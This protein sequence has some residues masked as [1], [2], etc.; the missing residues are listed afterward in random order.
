M[1]IPIRFDIKNAGYGMKRYATV[2]EVDAAFWE[3]CMAPSAEEQG[4][5]P[6]DEY[7]IVGMDEHG[8]ESELNQEQVL[9]GMREQGIWGFITEDKRIHFWADEK[10]SVEVLVRFFAHEVGHHTG[11]P[12]EDPLKEEL[13]AEQFASVA[14][15]A[16]Q[17]AMATATGSAMVKEAAMQS[18]AAVVH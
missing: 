15:S 2:E 16:L 13:R 4:L 8:N 1:E 10:C 3:L 17:L 9:D 6:N 11:T 14:I 7:T 5:S 18:K 12:E